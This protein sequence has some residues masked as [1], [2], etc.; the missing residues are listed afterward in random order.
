MLLSKAST[1]GGEIF[2]QAPGGAVKRHGYL[3]DL[4]TA[5]HRN[6]RGEISGCYLLGKAHNAAQ[7]SRNDFRNYCRKHQRQEQSKHSG[8]QQ[9]GANGRNLLLHAGKGIREAN[10]L[11]P[12]GDGQ[13]KEFNA[14]GVAYARR[15]SCF[16]GERGHYF[17]PAGMVFHGF[18]IGFRVGKHH[19]IAGDDGDARLRD[20]RFFI[21]HLLQRMLVVIFNTQRKALGVLDKEFFNVIVYRVFPGVPD[22]DIKRERGRG[23]YRDKR[24]HGFKENTVSHLDASNLYPAPRT[25]LRYLGSSGSCS[26]FSRSRR[27]YTSTERGVTKDRSR[28]TASST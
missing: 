27:I 5:G 12:A 11:V 20:A 17:R 14:N 16:S 19:A 10:N 8:A 7:P 26:I 24:T 13:I 2:L 9:V 4:V 21:G 23:N 15:T 1:D 18:R 28:H 25:V 6:T 22:A 3:G